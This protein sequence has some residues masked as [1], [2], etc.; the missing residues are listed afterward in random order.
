MGRN[1]SK[2]MLRQQPKPTLS[3]NAKRAVSFTIKEENRGNNKMT[4]ILILILGLILSVATVLLNMS[5]II[6]VLTWLIPAVAIGYSMATSKDVMKARDEF[7]ERVVAVKRDKMGLVRGKDVNGPLTDEVLVRKWVDLTIPDNLL[8]KMPESFDAIRESQFMSAFNEKMSANGRWV[9]DRDDE[10][11]GGFNYQKGYAVLK[12]VKPLP[13]RADWH[14]KWVLNDR[15]AWSFFPLAI[16]SENGVPVIDPETG[17]EVH[18]LGFALG[19]HQN[20]LADK[21]GFQ[22]GDEI[23]SSPQVL[24]AGGTGGG[25]SLDISTPIQIV[26]TE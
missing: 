19:S 24:I 18:V 2:T 8:I 3:Q 16:G 22:V 7:Y 12:R 25:K 10:E 1:Q 4:F 23:T 9:A 21:M 26:D 15:V 6:T 17:E 13:R 11:Y 20:K 14:E 5:I